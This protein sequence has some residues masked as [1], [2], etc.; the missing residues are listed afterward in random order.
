MCHLSYNHL[1]DVP[2][3]LDQKCLGLRCTLRGNYIVLTIPYGLSYSTHS[4]HGKHSKKLVPHSSSITASSR[5]RISISIHHDVMKSAI[6]N[7]AFHRL[8]IH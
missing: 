3:I 1:V 6:P 2:A 4:N 8:H 7:L 5:Q